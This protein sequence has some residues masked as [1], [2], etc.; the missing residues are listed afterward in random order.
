M[1]SDEAG[2]PV[3]QLSLHTVPHLITDEFLDKFNVLMGGRKNDTIIIEVIRAFHTRV[4][5]V[6]IITTSEKY[7]V[8]LIFIN[9]YNF[10]FFFVFAGVE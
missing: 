8:H 1:Q 7:E 9:M 5:N 4:I 10:F 6:S 3:D 2:P